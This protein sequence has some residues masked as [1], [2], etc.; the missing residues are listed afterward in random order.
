MTLLLVLVG[1]QA[2]KTAVEFSQETVVLA[3]D[4]FS[5]ASV[6]AVEVPVSAVFVQS[7]IVRVTGAAR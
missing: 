2:P 7:I 5:E 6:A 1:K 3:F 4:N